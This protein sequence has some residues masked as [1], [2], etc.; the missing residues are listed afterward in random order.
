MSHRVGDKLIVQEAAGFALAHDVVRLPAR[1]T[2]SADITWIDRKDLWIRLPETRLVLSGRALR[3][4]ATRLKLPRL[5][6]S[7]SWRSQSLEMSEAARWDGA[8]FYGRLAGRAVTAS[9]AT[10]F[11]GAAW[12]AH[13]RSL[14]E[15]PQSRSL[16][17]LAELAGHAAYLGVAVGA[18]RDE[19]LEAFRRKAKSVHPDTG[20]DPEAFKR[21]LAARE[22]LLLQS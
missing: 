20:G 5:T 22:A 19:V 3:L 9:R 21:L 18:G 16:E 7:F 15:A 8:P 13:L 4:P 6:E 12:E 11:T 17:G 14:G 2:L 10:Y 1:L